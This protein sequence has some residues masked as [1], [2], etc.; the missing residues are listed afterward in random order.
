MKKK[1]V[2]KTIF[3]EINKN[4][5]IKLTQK[6]IDGFEVGD[7]I[8]ADYEEE[9]W[10]ENNGMDSHFYFKIIREREETDEEFENRKMALEAQKKYLKQRRYEH[11]LELKKEFEG[12]D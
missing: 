10:T 6:M 11:Y 2:Q 1:M 7:I 9:Q 12:E 5:P 3:N 8:F 4:E